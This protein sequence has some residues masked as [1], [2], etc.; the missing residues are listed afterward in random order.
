ME[1]RVSKEHQRPGMEYVVTNCSSE[2]ML[3]NSPDGEFGVTFLDPA[4]R[5][6]A[7]TINKHRYDLLLAQLKIYDQQPDI[8]WTIWCWKD[9]GT[10]GLFHVSSNS[11]YMALLKPFL[12]KKRVSRARTTLAEPQEAAVD[13][14]GVDASHLDYLF[15]PMWEW[16]C[17]VAPSMRT[18]Y[19]KVFGGDR[20][21]HLFRP[22]RLCL[23]AV[24]DDLSQTS[25]AAGRA[26]PRVL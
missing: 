14:W 23:L 24:S 26:C 8:S 7:A 21:K 16:L 22:V 25:D 15:K 13:S 5:A 4:Q 17:D 6:D 2:H 12:D 19:P 20:G 10:G 3:T 18:R 9:L 1:E 11:A